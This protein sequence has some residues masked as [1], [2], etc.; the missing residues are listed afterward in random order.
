MKSVEDAVERK[1]RVPPRAERLNWDDHHMALAM[2]TA[3][4]SPDPNTQVGAVIVDKQN[5]VIGIGHNGA[6]RGI[7]VSTVP[8][9]R[10]G[11]PAETKYAYVVHAERNAILNCTSKIV[12]ATLYVTMFPCNE[13]AKDILQ[14][15]ITRVVYLTNPY[16]DQWQTQVSW[17]MLLQKDITVDRHVWKP[18]SLNL[19]EDCFLNK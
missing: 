2:V 5:R 3:Q 13:C 6:P 16:A 10:E 1:D 17:W 15:G 9:N 19:L 18:E 7:C 14:T 4:K 12:G 11:E 8:W